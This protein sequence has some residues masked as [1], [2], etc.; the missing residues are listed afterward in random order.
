MW[1]QLFFF[2]PP[3]EGPRDRAAGSRHL[4][5]ATMKSSTKRGRRRN[6]TNTK[7]QKTKKDSKQA[8]AC[9][10]ALACIRLLA[11]ARLDSFR[12]F[13]VPHSPLDSPSKKSMLTCIL[14]S[15]RTWGALSRPT[16]TCKGAGVRRR[17]GV[18]GEYQ[19]AAKT[20]RDAVAG[21]GFED[22]LR[23]NGAGS[24]L[25]PMPSHQTDG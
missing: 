23:P 18:D 16:L 3:G 1:F 21:D 15:S 2:V 11:Y 14:L 13:W 25:C 12:V 5:I 19:V 6:S 17:D 22:L 10:L 7:K 20:L 8:Y 9:L 4:E 24:R